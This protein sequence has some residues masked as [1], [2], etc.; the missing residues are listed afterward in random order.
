LASCYDCNSCKSD[1]SQDGFLLKVKN[2][3]ENLKL[4]ENIDNIIFNND[5]SLV[6]PPNND[7][8]DP[9]ISVYNKYVAKNETRRKIDFQLT[10]EQFEYFVKNNCFYCGCEPNRVANPRS[11]NFGHLL[12]NG[13]DRINNDI[14]YVFD[15][16][17]SCC[18]TCNTAKSKRTIEEFLLKIKTIYEFIYMNNSV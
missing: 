4:N 2:I 12:R 9:W 10:K 5:I 1:I 8:K 18:T 6:L 11:V 17:I 14:G 7:N 15:N 16:C 3:Y 13:I